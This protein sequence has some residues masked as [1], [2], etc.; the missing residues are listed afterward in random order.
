MFVH[1]RPGM[2]VND[3]IGGG[4]FKVTRVYG[5]LSNGIPTVEGIKFGDMGVIRGFDQI[6]PDEKT[7]KAE[8]RRKAKRASR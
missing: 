6:A 5:T 2:T 1:Y 7:L 3:L 4:T 8:A